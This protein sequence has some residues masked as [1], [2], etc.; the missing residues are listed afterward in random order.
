M[1]HLEKLEAKDGKDVDLFLT[2]LKL[3]LKYR[4]TRDES[5]P[6]SIIRLKKNVQCL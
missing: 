1:G 2:F 5:F 4:E 6:I 3:F